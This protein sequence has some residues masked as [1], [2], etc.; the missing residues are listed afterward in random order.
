MVALAA[1]RVVADWLSVTVRGLILQ[2]KATYEL[3]TTS[4]ASEELMLSI[5]LQK[6]MGRTIGCKVILLSTASCPN[7]DIHQVSRLLQLTGY[8]NRITTDGQWISIALFPTVNPCY[9]ETQLSIQYLKTV[10]A[11]THNATGTRLCDQLTRMQ[12]IN[13]IYAYAYGLDHELLSVIIRGSLPLR[14]SSTTPD[15]QQF[16]FFRVNFVLVAWLIEARGYSVSYRYGERECII[17]TAGIYPACRTWCRSDE[18]L[19][20]FLNK[21]RRVAAM[22]EKDLVTARLV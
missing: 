14:V 13:E 22:Y 11:V 18:R 20:L 10:S 17:D 3:V 12:R 4:T 19:S 2:T 1:L 16:D 5:C 7:C 8:V 21:P 9:L 6:I 15:L